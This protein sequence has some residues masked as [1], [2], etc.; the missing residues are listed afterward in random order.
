M[1]NFVKKILLN[2]SV[3]S[4]LIANYG[5]TISGSMLSLLFTPIYIYYLSI[6]AYGIIGFIASLMVFLNFLDLG[7][8][9]TVNREMAKFH[10]D[11]VHVN[12]LHNLVLYSHRDLLC[13]FNSN[14]CTCFSYQMV[15]CRA[16]RHKYCYLCTYYPGNYYCLQAALLIFFCS[17]K[18]YAVPGFTQFK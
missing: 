7:M 8:G 15:Q 10:K 13:T 5:T 14:C 12:Y 4:N 11:P 16:F 3:V 1:P 18:R 17:L 6:E 2:K 9:Q